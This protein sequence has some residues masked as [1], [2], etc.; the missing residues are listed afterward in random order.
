DEPAI[1]VLRR[2]TR[3]AERQWLGQE[4]HLRMCRVAMWFRLQAMTAVFLGGSTTALEWRPQLPRAAGHPAAFF[5]IRQPGRQ[6]QRGRVARQKQ[7]DDRLVFADFLDSQQPAGTTQH[8][9][10]RPR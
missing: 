2:E 1:L 8:P 5:L 10:R 3:C 6:A 4:T 7:R 9:E